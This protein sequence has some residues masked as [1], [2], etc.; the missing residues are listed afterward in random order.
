MT[1]MDYADNE[2]DAF[3]SMFALEH[4]YEYQKS[5]DEAY[6]SLKPGGRML[7]AVPWMY[8]YHAAPDD[9][10]R[11]SISALDR[12]LDRF[13]ILKSFAFGN[14]DLLVSQ[15]F[16]EKK[17]LG[18]RSRQIV[19]HARRLGALPFLISGL[20]GNQHDP[21]YAITTLYLCEKPVS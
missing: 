19:M 2:V 6:R 1:A 16:H 8:Y 14:R 13:T 15:L 11:F 3:L 10:F 21:V 7:L 20:L 9:F 18:H 4:I 17:A 5:I 12:M